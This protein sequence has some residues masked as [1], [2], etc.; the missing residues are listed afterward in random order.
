MPEVGRN[1]PCP[2]GS[3]L[4]FKRCC[5][6]KQENQDRAIR[7]A[8]SVANRGMDLLLEQLVTRFDLRIKDEAWPHFAP[9]GL[10]MTRDDPVV[11]HLFFPWAIFHWTPDGQP[12]ARE[13]LDASDASLQDPLLRTWVETCC[14]APFTFLEV[15]S[16]DRGRGVEVL[17]LLLGRRMF[18]HDLSLSE[19]ARPWLVFFGKPVEVDGLCFLEAVGPTAFEP[20]LRDGIVEATRALLGVGKRKI[21]RSKDLLARTDELLALYWEAAESTRHPQPLQLQNTD[22]H[23]LVLCTSTYRVLNPALVAQALSHIEGVEANDGTGLETAWSWTRPGN[24]MH[25]EWDNTVIASLRLA[26][27]ILR[28]E[29]N[30][31]E[32][33]AALRDRLE[34]ECGRLLDFEGTDQKDATNED[35]IRQITS[36]DAGLGAEEEVRLPPEVERQAM[37]EFLERHYQSWPDKPLPALGGKTPRQA[38]RT[39]EGRRQV[40]GV[41]RTMEFRN[42]PDGVAFDFNTLRRE[43]GLT[44]P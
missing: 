24:D 10:K 20:Q 9:D 19:V 38:I 36:Q 40:E 43:L 42:S 5:A 35:A 44:E 31:T 26:D 16:V 34:L 22:G 21:L 25:A 27:S 29:T 15:Q 1:D 8:R 6:R 17:D 33:D 12:P 39:K 30:S 11:A 23:P 7:T 18:L 13:W 14:D 41:I 3:G 4:K 37:S 2:C 32:R 28:L